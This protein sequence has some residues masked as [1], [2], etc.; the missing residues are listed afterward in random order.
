M[1]N[2]E[3]AI[4]QCDMRIEELAEEAGSICD[5][6]MEFHISENAGRDPKDKARLN[7][8]SRRRDR[9]LEIWWTRFR[10]N[11]DYHGGKAKVKYFHIPKGP[12]NKYREKTL[13]T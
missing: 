5:E 4:A 6:F 10:F 13:V 11:K 2:L 3:L 8:W 12:Q 9:S 1:A 7:C